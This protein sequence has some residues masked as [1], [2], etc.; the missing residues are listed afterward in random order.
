[1]GVWVPNR[2]TLPYCFYALVRI[3]RNPLT[4]AFRFCPP[5]NTLNGLSKPLVFFFFFIFLHLGYLLS[6]F[7]LLIFGCSVLLTAV[8]SLVAQ[9]ETQGTWASVAAALAALWHV[10]S[11]WARV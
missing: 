4:H 8:A 2:P 7:Y 5:T 11:S 3:Y 9:H 6:K 1:M 10:Q